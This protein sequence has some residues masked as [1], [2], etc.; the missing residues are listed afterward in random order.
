MIN[1]LKKMPV[2]NEINHKV[3][4]SLI[5]EGHIVKRFYHKGMTVHEQNTRCKVI[6]LVYSGE[7]VAYSLSPSGS[8]SIVFE[9]SSGSIIGANL[10][11]ADESK[12]PMS[13]YCTSDCSLFQIS[14]I[15][16]ERLLKEYSFVIEFIKSL[17]TNAQGMNRKIVMYKQKS[18]RNNLIDYFLALS[19]NQNSKTVLLP[20]TKKQLADYFGVQ[21][22]SL[23]RELKKMKDE[24]IIKIDNRNITIL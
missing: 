18:L 14:K 24:N 6:D 19:A 12:Y 3:L 10:L 1:Q 13:I 8:E 15:G 2:F 21:R 20:V 23:F 17:S 4:N 7:L 22:P 11:F 16:V 9:F 5:K